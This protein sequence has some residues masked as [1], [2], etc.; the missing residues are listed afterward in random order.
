MLVD[1]VVCGVAVHVF[2]EVEYK[3]MMPKPLPEADTPWSGA[4]EGP[5]Q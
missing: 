1:S 2:D 5:R 4:H 3:R